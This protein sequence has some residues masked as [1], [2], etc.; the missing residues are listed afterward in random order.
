MTFVHITNDMAIC[1]KLNTLSGKEKNFSRLYW[2]SIQINLAT[3][4]TLYKF[5]QYFGIKTLRSCRF[6]ITKKPNLSIIYF[7][8][9]FTAIS[10]RVSIIE[11]R[12]LF[13]GTHNETENPRQRSSCTPWIT[14]QL[15][16]SLL[17]KKRTSLMRLSDYIN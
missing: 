11:Y 5:H 15:K 4:A 1:T 16:T 12:F 13:I 10:R 3:L 17:Y 7:H 6:S 8:I 2:I 9:I 14:Y